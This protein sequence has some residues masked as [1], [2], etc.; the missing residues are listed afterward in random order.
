MVFI[1]I[2]R[3]SRFWTICSYLVSVLEIFLAC[4][5]TQSGLARVLLHILSGKFQG[6][7]FQRSVIFAGRRFLSNLNENLRNTANKQSVTFFKVILRKICD[8]LQNCS[9]YQIF[10]T[11]IFGNFRRHNLWRFSKAYKT[12]I[13]KLSLLNFI[14]H[15]V[16]QLQTYQYS[17]FN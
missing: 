13:V 17:R 1:N 2:Y 4:F 7:K 8:N 6:V 14:L 5:I 12:F 3:L 9:F 16:D 11:K 10:F 15:A